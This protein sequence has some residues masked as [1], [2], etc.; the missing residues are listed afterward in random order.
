MQSPIADV[1]AWTVAASSSPPAMQRLLFLHP[2]TL[3]DSWPFPVDTLG[4]VVKAPSAVYPVLASFVSNLPLEIEIFDVCVTRASFTNHKQRLR[5]ADFIPNTQG[6][7]LKALD[8][9][10]TIRL[11]KALNPE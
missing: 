3:V 10:L 5:R 11:A 2:K 7:P 1:T 4:E 9:E 6:P 8:P